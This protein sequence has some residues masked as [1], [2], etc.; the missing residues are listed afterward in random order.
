VKKK[1]LNAFEGIDVET[2]EGRLQVYTRHIQKRKK[3]FWPPNV[4]LPTIWLMKPLFPCNQCR[5]V[6]T[7]QRRQAVLVR[8]TD[9]EGNVY[10]ECRE[11]RHKFIAK[12]QVVET[13]SEEGEVELAP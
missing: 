13:S 7:E 8:A 11:C 12:M 3:R 6:V 9:R 2:F 1:T 4:P 10:L 5:A